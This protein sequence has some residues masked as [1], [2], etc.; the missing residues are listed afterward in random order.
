MDAADDDAD[1][2]AAAMGFSS[3]GAQKPPN[4]KR[5]YNPHADASTSVSSTHKPKP[6]SSTGANSAPLGTRA[7]PAPATNTDEIQL[8]DDDDDEDGGGNAPPAAAPSEISQAQDARPAS[9]PQRPAA[10]NGFVGTEHGHGHGGGRNQRGGGHQGG[11]QQRNS[12]WYE[13]YYDHLSN[14]NP[15]ARLEKKAGLQPRGSWVDREPAT[16]APAPTPA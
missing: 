2:M 3:F 7:P 5:K 16:A 4:K 10:G 14:E 9:L 1:A 6:T 13:N 15:W 8:D 12:L 11:H